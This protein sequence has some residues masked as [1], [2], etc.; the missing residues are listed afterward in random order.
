MQESSFT[1][2]GSWTTELTSNC[3]GGTC[4]YTNVTGLL[5]GEADNFRRLHGLECVRGQGKQSRQV[6]I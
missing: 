1:Y 4:K 3:D 6:G 5:L 2:F